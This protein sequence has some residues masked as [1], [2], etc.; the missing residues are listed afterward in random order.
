MKPVSF[1][2]SSGGASLWSFYSSPAAAREPSPLRKDGSSCRSRS[3]GSWLAH[4]LRGDTLR[5]WKKDGSRGLADGSAAAVIGRSGGTVVGWA[6]GVMALGVRA[7]DAGR[8]CCCLSCCHRGVGGAEAKGVT[9]VPY[10]C[11]A[12]GARL[13]TALT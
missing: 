1:I 7:L 5:P 11:E 8:I 10:I 2:R 3:F 4:G 13:T 9:V 12:S 6:R